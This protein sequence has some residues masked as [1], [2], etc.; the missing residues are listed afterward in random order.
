MIILCIFSLESPYTRP[1]ELAS[2]ILIY[3]SLKVKINYN[4]I[5]MKS[6]ILSLAL[7]ANQILAAGGGGSG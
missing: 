3:I 4:F 6:L 7:F 1:S 2:T 5:D